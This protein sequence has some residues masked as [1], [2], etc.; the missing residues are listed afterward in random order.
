MK[1]LKIFLYILSVPIFFYFILF[2]EYLGFL[3]LFLVFSIFLFR[4]LKS[5]NLW[6][7]L[8][9]FTL[10]L[11][12]ALHLWLGTYLFSIT[13]V[14]LLLLLFDRLVSNFFLDLI[15]VFFAF[16]LFKIFFSCFLFFQETGVLPTFDLAFL[17][18]S[19][20]FAFKNIFFYILLRSVEYLFKSYFRNSPF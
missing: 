7:L 19:L 16:F 20:L 18:T 14:L 6:W 13:F 5:F 9:L 15:A 2:F 1:I 10:F 11:D 4:D 3:N 12:V 8:L 17:T